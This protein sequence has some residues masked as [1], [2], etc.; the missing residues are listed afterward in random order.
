MESLC[1]RFVNK[2][3]W[4]H[5]IFVSFRFSFV[6][7]LWAFKSNDAFSHL[8]AARQHRFV[9]AKWVILEM[10]YYYVCIVYPPDTSASILHAWPSTTARRSS[11]F[12]FFKADWITVQ[13]AVNVSH[14]LS[15]FFCFS[16]S[17]RCGNVRTFGWTAKYWPLRPHCYQ[18]IKCVRAFALRHPWITHSFQFVH[19]SDSHPD[20]RASMFHG[21]LAMW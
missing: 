16:L 6:E 11:L 20:A 12:L 3:K 9:C 10:V 15:P 21:W 1:Y 8:Y 2:N 4:K 17:F 14:L 19:I 13:I 7:V 18:P 5:L